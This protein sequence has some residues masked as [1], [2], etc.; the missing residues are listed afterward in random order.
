MPKA[1]SAPVYAGY[2]P[3][4]VGRFVAMQAEF[5]AR[6]WG[7]D[8][9]YEAKIAGAAAAFLARLDPARDAIVTAWSNDR[10][11]GAVSVD[12]SEDDGPLAHLRWFVVG[13]GARGRGVGRALLVR[14]VDFARESGAKGL[15]L[16]TFDG[17]Q[18]ARA[19]YDAAG[20][21]VTEEAWDTTWGKRVLEQRME[22]RFA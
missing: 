5:Y 17:L 18:A 8:A 11:I 2:V 9:F 12:G 3:G 20:F 1:E 7:F 21:Q 19:L 4:V 15:Y 10:L 13:E 16:T 14:A 6:H 22:V